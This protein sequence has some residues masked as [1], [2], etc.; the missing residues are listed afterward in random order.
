MRERNSTQVK[1]NKIEGEF[2]SSHKKSQGLNQLQPGQPLQLPLLHLSALLSLKVASFLESLPVL[3]GKMTSVAVGLHHRLTSSC[4]H[5]GGTGGKEFGG[6]CRRHK[7]RG[8]DPWVRT[9]PWRRVWQPSPASLPGEP[10]GQISLMGYSLQSCKE[11]DM[12]EVNLAHMYNHR[13]KIFSLKFWR[14]FQA[15]C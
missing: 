2:I 7:R 4:D 5:T 15:R 10:H 3:E 14:K 11:S 8:F 13:G 9:I 1:E 6:Q 12:T